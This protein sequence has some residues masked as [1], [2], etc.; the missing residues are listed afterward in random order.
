[1]RRAYK[2]YDHPVHAEKEQRLRR[3]GYDRRDPLRMPPSRY[4]Y[5]EPFIPHGLTHNLNERCR[6]VETWGLCYPRL[7]RDQPARRLYQP[8]VDDWSDK[9]IIYYYRDHAEGIARFQRMKS[10]H[11]NGRWLRP[12]SKKWWVRNYHE[13]IL[14]LQADDEN[15]RLRYKYPHSDYG[16]GLEGGWR[17]NK[18]YHSG[19]GHRRRRMDEEDE[20][21]DDF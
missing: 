11:S 2:M 6:H 3:C 17:D 15:R 8:D 21:D 20:E 5:H 1:M 19:Y 12:H 4:P 9:R 13:Y 14:E 7:D 10:R 16:R 18:P